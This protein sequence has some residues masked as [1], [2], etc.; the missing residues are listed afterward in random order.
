MQIILNHSEVEDAIRTVVLSQINVKDG[1]EFS[2]DF[3]T[4]GD[5]VVVYV[6]IGAPE[7]NTTK[8]GPKPKK[9]GRTPR[10]V[11]V[12][13]VNEEDEKPSE[14]V[15]EKTS[16]TKAEKEQDT[17]E[18]EPEQEAETKA[19][20]PSKKEDDKPVAATNESQKIFSSKESSSVPL[21]PS[22]SDDA[23]PA[24]SLFAN[25]TRPGAKA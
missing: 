12:A 1:Q 15:E 24:T 9:R 10:A 4:S 21:D 5:E 8:R 18:P 2:F 20:E 19:D 25:L 7:E 14:E 11:D 17:K 3:D 22:A 13:D 23:K 6:G 16:D